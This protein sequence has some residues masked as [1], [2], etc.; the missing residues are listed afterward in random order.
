MISIRELQSKRRK[1][2]CSLFVII[3]YTRIKEIARKFGFSNET[4]VIRDHLIKTMKNNVLR[5]KTIRKNWTLDQILEEAELNEETRIQAMEIENKLEST[6][7][8]K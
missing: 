1:I 2:T 6:E 3:Y 8:I 5:I 4:E 7:I